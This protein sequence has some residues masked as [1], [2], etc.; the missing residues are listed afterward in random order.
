MDNPKNKFKKVIVK[1]E[2]FVAPNGCVI[3]ITESTADDK[4]KIRESAK[5]MIK[6]FADMHR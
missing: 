4:E 6:E 5:E 2:F 1:R 3:D